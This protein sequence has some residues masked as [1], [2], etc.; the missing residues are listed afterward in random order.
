MPSKFTE[1]IRDIAALY[2]RKKVKP[3]SHGELRASPFLIRGQL[4]D[5]TLPLVGLQSLTGSNSIRKLT[6]DVADSDSIPF[7]GYQQ[8]S[9][10]ASFL[11]IPKKS[12]PNGGRLVLCLR[13]RAGLGS[14]GVIRIHGLVGSAVR[15]VVGKAVRL[16]N[17]GELDV[18]TARDARGEYHWG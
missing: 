9:A 8:A 7:T 4:P 3:T 16:R 11:R 14:N 12:P 18:A 15:T 2:A 10:Y 17:Q 13:L 1:S 5:L 6:V